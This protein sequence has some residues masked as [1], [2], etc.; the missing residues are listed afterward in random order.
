MVRTLSV[1]LALAC[2]LL[3]VSAMAQLPE[4]IAALL[5]VRTVA[6]FVLALGVAAIAQRP[7]RVFVVPVRLP[8]GS[9][10]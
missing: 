1:S 9:T 8:Q 3:S 6:L 10:R 5:C 4:R 2:I 7:V